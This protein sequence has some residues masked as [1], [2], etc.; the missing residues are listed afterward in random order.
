L[1]VLMSATA[2]P[3]M[4]AKV[5]RI[6]PAWLRGIGRSAGDRLQAQHS[7]PRG[8]PKGRSVF[9]W[10]SLCLGRKPHAWAVK[11]ILE[12]PLRRCSK[13]IQTEV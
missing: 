11:K 3:R 5:V 2:H 7:F 6:E 13:D 9:V 1:L 4:W 10:S 12:H 8:C